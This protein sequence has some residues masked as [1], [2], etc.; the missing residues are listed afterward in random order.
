[1]NIYPWGTEM[2]HF[3]S[4]RSV[5]NLCSVQNEAQFILYNEVK[6]DINVL[7]DRDNDSQWT[8]SARDHSFLAY[9]R[10]FVLL[11]RK[12]LR[13][14]QKVWLYKGQRDTITFRAAVMMSETPTFLPYILSFFSLLLWFVPTGKSDHIK[15]TVRC[16]HRQ[17]SLTNHTLRHTLPS[18]AFHIANVRILNNV[19]AVNITSYSDN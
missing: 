13:H 15:N 5:R 19:L 7:R 4:E 14:A 6:T 18:S 12:M 16:R 3:G 11:S 9:S 1:M 17:A 10:L 8:S 2:W